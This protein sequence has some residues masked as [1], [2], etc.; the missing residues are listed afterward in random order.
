MSEKVVKEAVKV[1]LEVLKD[2]VSSVVEG[3]WLE[4]MAKLPLDYYVL[5]GVVMG[6]QYGLALMVTNSAQ[7]PS[8]P[9][10][11]KAIPLRNSYLPVRVVLSDSLPP[12]Y[13]HVFLISFPKNSPRIE[14]LKQAGK[15][16]S[17]DKGA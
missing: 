14:A 9:G 11:P 5:D 6:R 1:L 4:W 15:V 12:L 16:L 13:I 7:R 2:T 8:V 3:H 10:H 17:L